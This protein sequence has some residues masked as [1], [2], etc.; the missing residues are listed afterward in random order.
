M[1][2]LYLNVIKYS[3]KNKKGYYVLTNKKKNYINVG[4]M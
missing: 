3:K 4:S 2:N 1:I